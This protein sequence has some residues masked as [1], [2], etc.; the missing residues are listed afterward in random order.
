ML[1]GSS[2]RGLEAQSS[3]FASWP[4]SVWGMPLTRAQAVVCY[5]LLKMWWH[6]VLPWKALHVNM[7]RKGINREDTKAAIRQMKCLLAL[8]F[9]PDQQ[10]GS[11]EGK[12]NNLSDF[13][14]WVHLFFVKILKRQ[15]ISPLLH[16]SPTISEL[17]SA[18]VFSRCRSCRGRQCCETM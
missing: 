15:I 10:Q 13:I 8:F 14:D 2:H 12:K 4:R 16:I 7:E 5:L 9:P 18:S 1:L 17:L 11:T 6:T 3:I